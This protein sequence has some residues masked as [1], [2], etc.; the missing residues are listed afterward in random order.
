M[1]LGGA[2]PHAASFT[3]D[4]SLPYAGWRVSIHAQ[5]VREHQ[6][7]WYFFLKNQ[8]PHSD[9]EFKYHVLNTFFG[10]SEKDREQVFKTLR[11]VRIHI[12]DPRPGVEMPV[13]PPSWLFNIT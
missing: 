2:P 5:I 9:G 6:I 11:T 7:N 4:T 12:V 10:L 13:K 3:D 8:T 1:S